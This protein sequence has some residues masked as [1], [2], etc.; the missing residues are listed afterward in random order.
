MINHK[1]PKNKILNFLI[2]LI[3]G[4]LAITACSLILFG[5]I[6]VIASITKFLGIPE[7]FLG[8]IIVV[9]FINVILFLKIKEK[10]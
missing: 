4:A 1:L 5:I 9:I 8:Y 2:A 10:K 7:K 6:Y 3:S